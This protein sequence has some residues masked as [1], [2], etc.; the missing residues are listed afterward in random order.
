MIGPNDTD[1]YGP[2]QMI[3]IPLLAAYR[4]E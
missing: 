2:R 4:L 1:S 3:M